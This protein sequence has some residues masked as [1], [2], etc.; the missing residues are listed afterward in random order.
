MEHIELPIK[1]ELLVKRG[2]LNLQTRT[3]GDEQRENLFHTRCVVQEKWLND[4]GE[5][6][7]ENQVMVPLSIGKYEDEILCDVLPMHAG[8]ILF[9]RSWQSDRRVNHDGFTNRYSFECK[10]KKIVLVPLTP[11]EVHQ[12][13][14]SLKKSRTQEMPSKIWFLLQKFKVV[15]PEENPQGLPPIRGIV[16]QIDFIPGASLPNKP[17][18]RTNPLETKELQQQVNELMEKS[19]IRESMSPC[20]VPVLLVPK[21]DDSWRMCVDCRAI[22]NITI[23][24]RHPIPRLDD[25]LDDLHRSSIFSKDYM[26]E[27][28]HGLAGFKDKESGVAGFYRR[29]IKDF[30]SLAAPLT[31]VIKKNVGFKW[32]HAQEEAFQALKEKLTNSLILSLL[33]FNKTF[34]IE[35][36]SSGVGIGAVLMREKKPTHYLW[37]KEFVIHADHESLK[38]LKGQQ[39]LNKRHTRWIK[40]IE[41][42]PY[43]IKYKKGKDNVVADALYRRFCVPNSSLRDL[44]D[45]EGHAGGLMG[46][47]GVTKTMKVMQEHFFWLCMKKDVAKT[48]KR[49]TTCKKAK[50]KL[51]PHEFAYN[52]AKHSTSKYSPFEIVYGFNPLSP[53]DLML[54]PVSE[55]ASLDVKKKAE[56]VKQIHQKAR[57]NLESKTKLYAKHPYKGRMEVIFEE[58]DL[59]WIPLRKD[60][61]SNDIKSKLMPRVNGPFKITKK[62]DDNAYQLDLQCKYNKTDLRTNSFQVGEDDMIM[63]DTRTDEEE[64][65]NEQLEPELE[66][67]KDIAKD[68]LQP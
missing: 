55:R 13:Q 33:D 22:N 21:K 30:R 36:D 35:C 23:K 52:H 38:H 3:E 43:V 9:G 24:Y 68:Q 63:T 11:Q 56:L 6:E 42:F 67:A 4:Q 54:I 50:S 18:Y 48:C 14:M 17:V 60:R 10:G 1:G 57:I 62:I 41:T 29:L 37:P 58:G 28:F 66:E 31:E 40:F 39:K 16:H 27:D 26:N 34:E 12:D 25:M 47:F 46:H 44:L 8:Y 64:E 32:E 53:L 20:V 19:H 7:V 45:K 59:V 65:T 49:C 2:T 15:C 61:F 51:Q 5:L